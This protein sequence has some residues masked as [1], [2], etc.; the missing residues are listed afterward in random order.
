MAPTLMSLDGVTADDLRVYAS[1]FHTNP[2]LPEPGEDNTITVALNQATV[3]IDGLAYISSMT[4]PSQDHAWPRT[5]LGTPD[6]VVRAIFEIT[7]RILDGYDI[8]EEA[9]SS[10]V[11]SAGLGSVRVSLSN[12]SQ[13]RT[14][15]SI[16]SHVAWRLLYPYL[17]DISGVKLSR[18]S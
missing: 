7:L 3:A 12:T 4:D 17:V 9:E 15:L 16:I 2:N 8:E 10:G 1:N 5:G 14:G 6:K 13:E 18:V 11:T